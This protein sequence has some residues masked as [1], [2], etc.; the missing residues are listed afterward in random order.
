[1]KK[2]ISVAELA[3]IHG[4]SEI[5]IIDASWY[6]PNDSKNGKD[7]YLKAHIAGAQFFDIW[8]DIPS[9]NEFQATIQSLGV[10][11]DSHVIV[12][13]RIG[14]FSAPRLY[15]L[16]RYFGHSRV[17]ILDG[18]FPAWDGEVES[19]EA[20]SVIPGDFKAVANKSLAVGSAEIL[21]N[22]GKNLILDAR[23]EARF[24]GKEP[25]PREGLR[26]GHIP[27]SKNMPYDKLFDNNTGLFKQPK[28]LE[29]LMAKLLP[30]DKSAP[31]ICTCG[32]GVTAC[33]VLLALEMLGYNNAK[34][35]GGAWAEW[36]ADPNLPIE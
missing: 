10:D 26:S 9:E 12:Y 22:L 7:E 18:G 23:P 15:W 6:L 31:V 17:S 33:T 11:S 30:A 4:Q 20:K 16:L 1:M 19:G 29:Q 5:V 3:E 2:I 34:L 25:E 21:N 36:G 13:D 28:E 14:Y 35:Y 27:H 32:S 8:H 24:L